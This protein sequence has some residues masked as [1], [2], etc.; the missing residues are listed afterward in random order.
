[1]VLCI[2]IQSLE[3]GQKIPL[4]FSGRGE[5]KM[6]DVVLAVVHLKAKKGM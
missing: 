4:P 1:M 5:G 2:G 6:P 3:K